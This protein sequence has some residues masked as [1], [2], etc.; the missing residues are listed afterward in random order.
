MDNETQYFL[1][2]DGLRLCYRHWDCEDAKKIVCIVHGIGEHS[3]RYAHVAEAF[4][5]AKISVFALDLRGH[6]ISEG[7][8]GHARSYQLLLSDI[9]EL[10]KTAR[11]EYTDLPMYLYGHSM[12]GNLVA[13]YMIQMNTNELKGFVASAAWFRLAFDPPSWKVKLGALVSKFYPALTQPSGLDI[14]LLSKVPEVVKAY[15]EDP[16]VHN[17][18]SAGLYNAMVAAG[19]GA[20]ASAGRIKVPGLVIHGSADGINDWESSKEFAEGNKLIKFEVLE[21]VYHEPHNDSEQEQIIAKIRDWI[22]TH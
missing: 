8:K 16:M 18:I 21:G 20:I 3:G 6:G 22:L 9:E 7:K 13:N 10:L 17:K 19:E 5:K 11:A 14:S 1:S 4:N 2:Q 15:A 12:G